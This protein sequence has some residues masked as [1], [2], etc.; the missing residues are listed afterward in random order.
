MKCHET[1]FE[2]KTGAAVTNF[3]IKVPEF[4]AFGGGRIGNRGRVQPNGKMDRMGMIS[5]LAVAADTVGGGGIVE[6]LI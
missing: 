3:F 5:P 1:F 6:S 2:K 4:S